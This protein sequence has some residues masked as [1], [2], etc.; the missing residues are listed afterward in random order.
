M[1]GIQRKNVL[2][3]IAGVPRSFVHN[4]RKSVACEF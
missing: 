4:T 3:I 2:A 1:A